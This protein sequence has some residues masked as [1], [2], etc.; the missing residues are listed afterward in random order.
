MFRDI[1]VALDGSEPAKRAFG[2]A[3]DLADALNARLTVIT[4]VPDVAA[5]AYGA[6]VDVERLRQELED[7]TEKLLRWAVDSLPPG[8][9]I[10]KVTKHGHAGPRILEQLKAGNHDLLVMGSRGRG[11]LASNLLGSVAAHVYFHSRVPMLVVQ[12][13]E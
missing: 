6:Q 8:L 10:T 7:D 3:A 13:E 4:V 11:R 2:H 12:P 1:L 5:P 9:P